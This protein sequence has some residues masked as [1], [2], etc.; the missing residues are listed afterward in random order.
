MTKQKKERLQSISIIRAISITFVV[1]FH[2]YG[3][4]YASHFPATKE[5]YRSIYF[6]INQFYFI[7]IAMPMFVFVSAYLFAFLTAKNKYPTFSYLIKNKIKRIL[8]PYFCFGMIMMASTNNFHPLELLSGGF[9]HLWF[10]PMIFWCFLITYLLSKQR[11]CSTNKGTWLILLFC[12]VIALMDTFL[13]RILGLHNLTQWYCWF[14]LGWAVYQYKDWLMTTIKRFKLIYVLL[15]IYFVIT[16]VR[17]TEYGDIYWYSELSQT[18]MILAIWYITENIDWNK[19]NFIK[20]VI[21]FSN[22]SYGIYIYHNWIQLYLISK[23]AQKLFPLEMWA[24]E[25]TILFP[26]CF[27]LISLLISYG[28]TRLTLKTRVGK[29]LIG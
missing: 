12:F 17:P 13:P 5:L 18:S 28:L 24:A 8:L 7:N 29:F 15:F 20:P 10:L 19:Y 21:S 1:A 11:F 22:Y 6:P 16:I 2:A 9:W 26:F 4:M 27:F 14:Y 23:T 25:H 3:M